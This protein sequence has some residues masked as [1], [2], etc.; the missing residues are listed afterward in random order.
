MGNRTEIDAVEVV[1]RIRDEHAEVLRGK[2]DE[3]IIEFFRKAAEGFRAQARSKGRTAARKRVRPSSP[4][5]R[6]N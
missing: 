2:S 4:R 3:E 6:R 1:R 5:A